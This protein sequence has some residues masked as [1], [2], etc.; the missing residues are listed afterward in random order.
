MK[1]GGDDRWDQVPNPSK[2]TEEKTREYWVTDS[3]S[4]FL[5][6][7][8]NLD[9]NLVHKGGSFRRSPKDSVSRI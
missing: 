3:V 8:N 9:I 7:I 5:L 1:S 6:D 2:R 4:S